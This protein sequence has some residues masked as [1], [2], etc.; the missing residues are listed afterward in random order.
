MML[1]L[2]GSQIL[3]SSN[4]FLERVKLSLF[5]SPPEPN[6]GVDGKQTIY[7]V[8]TKWNMCITFGLNSI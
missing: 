6:L 8:I 4:L 2:H 7:V 3:D 5:C 1:S